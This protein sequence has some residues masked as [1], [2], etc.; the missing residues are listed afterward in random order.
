MSDQAPQAESLT[1]DQAQA[2]I[3]RLGADPAFQKD[4]L[5]G[6]GSGHREALAKWRSLQ[7]QAYGSGQQ[8]EAAP[9]H[10]E[11]L[12]AALAAPATPDEY[13]ITRDYSVPDWDH[14]LEAEA[15]QIAHSIGFS[16]G[17]L[18]GVVLAWNAAAAD[19]RAN[20][21]ITPEKALEGQKAGMA[22][23]TRKH[24]AN[25]AEVVAKARSVIDGMPHGQRQRMVELLEMSG[26][27]N[28]PYVIERL[29]L[30]A[31]RKAGKK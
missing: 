7:Q 12:A 20:G 29:A 14:E 23:L 1:A 24:G 21:P 4:L 27:G 30:L 10:G 2:E 15:K 11:S 17:D 22:T 5:S 26:L 28:N 31:D 9:D 25:T 19:I 16:N 18:E 8:A 13:R 6:M 3:T